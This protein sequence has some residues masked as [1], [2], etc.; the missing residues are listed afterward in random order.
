MSEAIQ[1]LKVLRDKIRAA[2]YTSEY[3][4][5]SVLA[6]IDMCIAKLKAER[7]NDQHLMDLGY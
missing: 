4:K 5:D 2:K 7:D 1:H 6:G 3:D